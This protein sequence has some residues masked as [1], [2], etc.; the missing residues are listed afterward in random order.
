VARV[1]LISGSTRAASSNTALLRT[2][3]VAAPA[4]IEA[5]LYDGLAGLPHFNPDDDREPLPVAVAELRSA[6]AASDAV[7]FCT[8]E[9]AGTLPPS[10]KNLLD[11][12]VGGTELSDKPVAWV[13][14]AADGRRGLGAQ[15]TLE[16]VL[17]YVQTAIVADA[18]RHV[19]VAP[20]AVGPDGLIADET[21]RAAIADVLLT[22]AK[23]AAAAAAFSS[24]FDQ[25]KVLPSPRYVGADSTM[26]ASWTKCTVSNRSHNSPALA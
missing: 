23:A 20:G 8:P 17:G 2:A 12:T 19:P 3:A 4:G 5:V 14:A 11:W 1:L 6:I 10:M 9:Y 21:T 16:T 18:C 13:N 26:V 7:L 22:L 25:P 15:A 24:G